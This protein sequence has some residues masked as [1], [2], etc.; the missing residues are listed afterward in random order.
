MR[1]L[2][3]CVVA[4]LFVLPGCKKK[5]E[6]KK[7]KKKKVV[8]KTPDPKKP[9]NKDPA[10]PKGD[11]KLI[12]RGAYLS[13]LGG[14]IGCHTSVGPKGPDMT[15]LGG[16][17]LE[18]TE[19]F[20]TWRSPNITPDKKTG[21]GSWTDQQI[22]DAIRTGKR[23]DGTMMY[24]I[25]PYFYYSKL[26][27]DDAKAIVAF[28]RSLKPVDNA[29]AGNDLKMPK[30]PGPVPAKGDAP[31]MKDPLKKG[32]YLASV[33]HCHMCHTPMTDK[34]PD[35]KKSWAGGFKM[36]IP[37]KWAAMF[38]HGTVYSS[39]IT[40]DKATGI[41][42]WTE[43]DIVASFTKFVK[44]DGK[45]VLGPMNFYRMGWSKMPAEDATAVAKFIKTIKA[46]KHK[47]PANKFTPPKPRSHMGGQGEG[48][49]H[50]HGSGMGGGKGGGGGGGTDHKHG[51]GMGGGKGGGKK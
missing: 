33:M 34:G 9:V 51:S 13:S 38:G 44:K 1:T 41:G 21:I 19:V 43:Q 2:G 8:K 26:S 50:K 42:D 46:I 16:G 36:E 45:P 18:V 40:Q 37:E 3:I 29:V 31:D 7:P 49:G 30:P 24:P 27:N 23:K 12:A 22:I 48:G 47:V 25:M 14:C 11:P 6:G 10:K 4:A 28:L 15:K 17:G 5:D 39:N 35:M 20:G 32:E